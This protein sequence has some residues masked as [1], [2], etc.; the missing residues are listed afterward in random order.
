MDQ[1]SFSIGVIERWMDEVDDAEKHMALFSADPWAVAD[2]T[3]VEVIGG[4]Y[5]RQESLWLRNDVRSITLDS[6]LVWRS[7]VPGTAVAAVGAFDS[8][9]GDVLLFRSMLLDEEGDPAPRIF[10]SGGTYAI[11]AGEYVVGLDVPFA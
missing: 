7:L 10:P 5:S 8:A 1:G 2:P 4:T 9:F 11:S 6:G 3:T